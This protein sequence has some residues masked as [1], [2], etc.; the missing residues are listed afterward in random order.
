[1]L[2]QC[3]TRIIIVSTWASKYEEYTIKS[4]LQRIS[5]PSHSQQTMASSTNQ[6]G[7][8]QLP[9][10]TVGSTAIPIGVNA[11]PAPGGVGGGGGGAPQSVFV[12]VQVYNLDKMI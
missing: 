2:E 1:M 10:V 9:H 11:A 8:Q 4:V 5:C 7:G 3:E 12:Y 6:S